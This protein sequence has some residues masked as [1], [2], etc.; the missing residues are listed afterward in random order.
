MI[1]G[2]WSCRSPSAWL[3]ES[4][5][6]IPG[7]LDHTLGITSQLSGC[8]SIIN[9]AHCMLRWAT[10]QVARAC[11]GISVDR[12]TSM[13][14][15]LYG[16]PSLH[17]VGLAGPEAERETLPVR[18]EPDQNKSGKSERGLANASPHK[19]AAAPSTG[20]GL[21]NWPVSQLTPS[22]FSPALE[23]WLKSKTTMPQAHITPQQNPPVGRSPK[24][25]VTV[26]QF[27]CLP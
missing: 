3:R 13:H 18:V 19:H 21:T 1:S 22:V 16:P 8:Q 6:L 5:L 27:H 14:R 2:Q 11:H 20:L 4:K 23:I 12:R 9:E 26:C 25:K 17:L 24:E 10:P 7:L 15:R